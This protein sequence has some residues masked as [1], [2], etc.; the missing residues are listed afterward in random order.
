M[1]L[2]A[3]T[4]PRGLVPT[5]LDAA[6]KE[7]IVGGACSDRSAFGQRR[8]GG[9]LAPADGTAGDGNGC[10]RCWWPAGGL[11]APC[12]ALGCARIYTVSR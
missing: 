1:I 6:M 4:S 2:D 9:P 10:S 3:V 11:L 12:P 5:R 8:Q 7:L